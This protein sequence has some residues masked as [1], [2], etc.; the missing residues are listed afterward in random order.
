[1]P[2]GMA[3]LALVTGATGFMA[4]HLIPDL[5]EEGWEVRA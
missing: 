3:R 4:Q 2:P 1:M 5:V